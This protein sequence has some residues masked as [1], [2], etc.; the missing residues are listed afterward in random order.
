MGEGRG[1][2]RFGSTHKQR[3][4]SSVSRQSPLLQLMEPGMLRVQLVTQR[5]LLCMR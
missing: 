5:R 3:G 1:R 2:V 4:P